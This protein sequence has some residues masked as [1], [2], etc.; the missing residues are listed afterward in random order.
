MGNVLGLTTAQW[1]GLFVVAAFVCLFLR[2]LQRTRAVLVFAGICMTG[3]MFARIMTSIAR[4]V[5]HLT[6][7][8]FA[9]MFGASVGGVLV[10]VIGG[11][12]IYDLHPRGGGASKR[13]FWIA[14]LS[15]GLL[16]AG[17]STFHVLNGIPGDVGTGVSTVT[18]G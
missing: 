2:T 4:T 12:L 17:V 6:D 11:I 1:G 16:V 3:G 13:T 14:A 5:S 7:A 9:K 8:L 15:A 10:L 18:G